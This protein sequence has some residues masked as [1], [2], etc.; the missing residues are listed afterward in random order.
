MIYTS[1]GGLPASIMTDQIQTVA[2]LIIVIILSIFALAHVDFSG[3]AYDDASS[4]PERGVEMGFSLCF[5]VFGAEVF[6][7]AFWQRVF[8]AKDE[9]ALRVGF[10]VGTALLATLTFLFGL[11]GI[12]LKAQAETHAKPIYVPAFLIFEINQMKA[13][14]DTVRMLLFVLATC[15][16]TSSVDSFQI[17]ISSVISR[18]MAKYKVSWMR[19]LVFGVALTA[20]VNVP[21]VA[22]AQFAATDINETFDGFA[23]K[24]TDL[25]SMADIVTITVVVPVFSGLWEFATPT[26]C[27]LGMFSGMA[28]VIVWGWMEFGTFIAGLEMTT[29]MCFGNTVLPD[30]TDAQ[31]APYP[32]C[33]FYSKRAPMIFPTIVF[34]SAVVTFGVSWME[35]VNAGLQKG[36]VETE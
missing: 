18:L 13:A 19:T 5:A 17:G 8:M 32:K 31:G 4:W 30:E 24:L 7:L 22:F 28:T 10:G 1:I 20:L 11:M 29:M 36:E 3:A 23:V 35:R 16:I 33:G 34:V 2:I 6:N 9:R 12:L 25:F 14:S 21:A 26:G 15:M 27:I